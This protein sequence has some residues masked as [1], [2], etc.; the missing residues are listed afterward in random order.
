[1]PLIL[2]MEFACIKHMGCPERVTRR[3][4][5]YRHHAL[6]NL[7]L[8]DAYRS[9]RE[10]PRRLTDVKFTVPA[11]MLV[12]NTSVWRDTATVVFN[13]APYART[14]FVESPGR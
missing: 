12:M 8:G 1:M 3:P 2:D 5:L 7:M 10:A 11:N 4:L 6:G 9:S 14:D 13:S